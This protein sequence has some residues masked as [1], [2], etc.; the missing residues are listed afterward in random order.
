MKATTEQR[1]TLAAAISPLDTEAVRES[2]RSGNFPRADVT[3]D[4][5]KRYRWDLLNAAGGW[6]LTA[7]LYDS[8]MDDT[9]I[10]TVLRSI[11]SPL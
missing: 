11:V 5:D 8:G 10:D 2:Y 4:R 9:H 3:K 1:A 7:P 6:K